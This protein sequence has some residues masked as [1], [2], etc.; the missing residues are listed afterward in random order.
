MAVNLHLPTLYVP[1][2]FQMSPRSI[3]ID[4]LTQLFRHEM[5]TWGNFP[6]ALREKGS[7]RQRE[8]LH[9]DSRMG[10]KKSARLHPESL[11]PPRSFPAALHRNSHLYF[12]GSEGD[13]ERARNGP[14]SRRVNRRR[15]EWSPDLPH[16]QAQVLRHLQ[17]VRFN[18]R[19]REEG[20]G[21]HSWWTSWRRIDTQQD[22]QG[23]SQRPTPRWAG[24]ERGK[25]CTQSYILF[26]PRE[27]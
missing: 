4:R 22:R 16:S 14:K 25:V 19:P 15:R 5:G 27:T 3:Q 24:W 10:G 12:P 8:H 20:R 13:G 21:G 9:A 7:Q 6:F 1:S 17:N 2:T 26:H 11:L 23:V 18:D